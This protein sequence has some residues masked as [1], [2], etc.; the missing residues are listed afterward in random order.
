MIILFFIYFVSFLIGCKNNENMSKGDSKNILIKNIFYI[1]INYFII[2]KH[3][4]NIS[5]D[6]K[7]GDIFQVKT[8]SKCST[9]Y[10]EKKI[11]DFLE[12]NIE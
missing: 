3:Q 8:N 9:Q 2:N 4:K 12:K 6:E 1:L 11:I 7:L 5:I 10:D